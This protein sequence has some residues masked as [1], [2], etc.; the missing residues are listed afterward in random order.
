MIHA[1][2]CKLDD[3]KATGTSGIPGEALSRGA[4]SVAVVLQPFYEFLWTHNV[5]PSSWKVARIQPVP[6]KGDLTLIGNYRPISLIEVIRKVFE[7]ILLAHVGHAAEPL[8]IEQGGF[9]A[10]RGTLD[11]IAVLQEWILQTKMD[12]R[13][14]FMAFLD[15]KAAYDQVDRERLWRKCEERGMAPNLLRMLQALFDENTAFVAING[16]QSGQFPLLSGVM[17]GSPLSPILYSIF[18]DDLITRLNAEGGQGAMIGGRTFRCLLYADDIVLISSSWTHLQ[19]MLRVCEDHSVENR[20]RFGVAKCE[21]VVSEEKPRFG[22]LRIYGEVLA[23]VESFMYLGMPVTANGVDWKAHIC[24]IGARTV[25]R[26]SMLN[27]IGCNGRGFDTSTCLKIYRAF[28]RPMLEYGICLCPTSHYRLLDTYAAKCI[29]LMTSTGRS[30]STLVTGMFCNIPPTRLRFETLQFKF[31]CRLD[32]RG[33]GF[34][35]YYALKASQRRP[36]PKTAFTVANSNELIRRRRDI[37]QRAALLRIEE[38]ALP[39]LVDY[40][41]EVIRAALAEFKS[42]YIFHGKSKF[43]RKYFNRLFGSLPRQDQRLIINWVLNRSAGKWKKCT[44][45]EIACARKKHLE[46]CALGVSGA[47]EGSP[48]NTEEMMKAGMT[49]VMLAVEWIRTMVGDRPPDSG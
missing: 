15:I 48:S 12:K 34:A 21:V 49:H 11:Q 27:G 28:V 26:A 42:A 24:R 6:K 39:T 5:I 47:A 45:C 2:I 40:Q 19:G 13:A 37:Q 29:R 31:A 25:N 43:E 10:R 3:G 36:V 38:P 30:T 1:K 9:R 7:T 35:I 32:K 16:S 33:D 14:R 4:D 17:Q 46:L 18:V 41:E 20:Y 23:R 22:A 8:N 44:H